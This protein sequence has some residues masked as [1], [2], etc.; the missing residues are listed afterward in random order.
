MNSVCKEDLFSK[1][2]DSDRRFLPIKLDSLKTFE[3]ILSESSSI[4]V[5]LL[6]NGGSLGLIASTFLS[7]IG[8]GDIKFDELFGDEIG[9]LTRFRGSDE[10]F[11]S[12]ASVCERSMHSVDL[13]NSCKHQKSW[14]II[15]HVYCCIDHNQIYIFWTVN[16]VYL[17]TANVQDAV[18]LIHL[19]KEE[20]ESKELVSDVDG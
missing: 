17:R 7:L 11:D 5:E 4:G 6:I 1:L 10:N 15:V 8:I 13:F 2:S 3:Y 12:W 20:G 19:T 14:R 9:L 16:V 18:V